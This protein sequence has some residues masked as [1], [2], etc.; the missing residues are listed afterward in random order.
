M[1]SVMEGFARDAA[2]LYP[3]LIHS[4]HDTSSP[5]RAGVSR[6]RSD[7]TSSLD[8]AANEI[9]ANDSRRAMP[10]LVCDSTTLMSPA[11]C[12]SPVSKDVNGLIVTAKIAAAC[13][14]NL[15]CRIRQKSFTTGTN[16]R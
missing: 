16:D 12:Q 6:Y 5:L 14:S 15:W 8:Y 9:G 10:P 2:A 13:F 7:C 11:G 4:I 3:P 1:S